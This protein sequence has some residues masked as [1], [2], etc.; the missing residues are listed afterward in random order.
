MIRYALT[1]GQQDGMTISAIVRSAQSSGGGPI[2]R[3][4]SGEAVNVRQSEYG[5]IRLTAET[6]KLLATPLITC[7][8]VVFASTDG[9]ASPIAAVYH[10]GGGYVDPRVLS[11]IWRDIGQPAPASLL[12]L[13][14]MP[15]PIDEGYSG[16]I[17]T[18]ETF[19]IPSNQV[20]CIERWPT[21][22][23]GINSHGQVGY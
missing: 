12:V 1:G 10:A 11:S 9:A 18:L 17:R 6:E 7:A 15:N 23:F 13:Y 16:D 20:V 22:S 8:G 21:S 14:A 4:A 5:L 19:G 3:I 2:P